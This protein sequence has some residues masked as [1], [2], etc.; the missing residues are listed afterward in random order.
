MKAPRAGILALL[1]LVGVATGC[2]RR[3]TDFSIISTKDV[4]VESASRSD[5]RVVG[6]DCVVVILFPWGVPDLE[7]AI[8]DA[9][10]KAGPGYDALIDGVVYYKDKSFLFG[11]VCYEIEGTPISTRGDR[12]ALPTD[13]PIL[14]HSRLG[15]S[16]DL[17]R[18]P[19][20]ELV[21]EGP[22]AR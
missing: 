18:V 2:S 1:V 19:V 5:K 11:K 14:Y 12:G 3:I 17:A 7:E 20:I 9:I 21:D 13:G 15:R 4:N 8:D 6:Q 10:E 16:N 22:A